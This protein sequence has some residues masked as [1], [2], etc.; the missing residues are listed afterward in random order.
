MNVPELTQMVQRISTKTSPSEKTTT[1]DASQSPSFMIN[2]HLHRHSPS[3]S[4]DEDD[5]LIS[6]MQISANE[7]EAGTVTKETSM[8]S[9]LD[10]FFEG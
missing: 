2:T 3:L 6:P 1:R 10:T 8:V 4:G 7:Q 5:F 9:F